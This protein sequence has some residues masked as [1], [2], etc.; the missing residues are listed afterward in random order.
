MRMRV[1]V[2]RRFHGFRLLIVRVLLILICL[3][4]LV[5]SIAS[6][7]VAH[8]IELRTGMHK[9][10]HP[11]RHQTSRCKHHKAR[12]TANAQLHT[13]A[14][15]D[16]CGNPSPSLRDQ[17][18]TRRVCIHT[19]TQAGLHIHGRNHLRRPLP[20][21]PSPPLRLMRKTKKTQRMRMRR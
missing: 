4:L 14:H 8:R 11:A 12:S 13:R 5:L 2:V 9:H 16:T 18:I 1:F 21:P 17:E 7:H 15:T 20:S 3:L 10:A 19:Q 6:A